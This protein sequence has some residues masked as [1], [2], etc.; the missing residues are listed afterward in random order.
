MRGLRGRRVDDC[1]FSDCCMRSGSLEIFYFGP[2]GIVERQLYQF[3]ILALGP[4]IL[5]YLFRRPSLDG[6]NESESPCLYNDCLP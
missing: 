2:E 6:S 4:L 3:R 5:R 1:F